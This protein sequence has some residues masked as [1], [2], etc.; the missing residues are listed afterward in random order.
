M[1][2]TLSL[3]SSSFVEE[4]H[5]TW[6]LLTVT[7]VLLLGAHLLPQTPTPGPGGEGPGL[8]SENAGQYARASK[9]RAPQNAWEEEF[10]QIR[11]LSELH[12]QCFSRA[13]P[14]QPA[15]VETKEGDLET[16]RPVGRVGGVG[17]LVGV[18]GASRVARAWNQ[19]GDKWAHLPD[20]GDWLVR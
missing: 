14:A 3:L 5:Q 15:D 11:Q 8:G 6:Y 1:G 4:E 2:H 13:K 10:N 9:D 18:L 12:T 17:A 7:A 20:V 19:T 16:K